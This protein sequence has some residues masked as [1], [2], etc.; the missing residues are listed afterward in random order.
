MRVVADRARDAVV[1]NVILVSAP[2]DR[3]HDDVKVVALGAY[4]VG[5]VN[6]QVG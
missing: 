4:S 5:T 1:V 2:R 3:L 6:G